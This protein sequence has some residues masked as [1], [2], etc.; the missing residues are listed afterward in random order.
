MRDTENRDIMLHFR[1]SPAELERIRKKMEDGG[2]RSMSAYLRKMA[3]NGYCINYN[4]DYPRQIS[5][6][7]RYC[8]NNLNQYS[9]KANATG[10][11]YAADIQDLQVRL[12][13]IWEKQKESLRALA[14]LQ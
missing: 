1:V 14:A 10:S 4:Y 9:K 12:D 13:E 3:L 5:K 6:L 2:I 7:L 8:S 11:I